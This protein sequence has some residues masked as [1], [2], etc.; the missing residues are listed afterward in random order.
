[1]KYT[2]VKNGATVTV[3]APYD[4]N[5]HC[6]FCVNKMDYQINPV[7]DLENVL[8]SMWRMDGITPLCDFVFT[9]GEPLA[10]LAMLDRMFKAVR[11]MN[12]KGSHHR[13]FV[14]TTFPVK[15]HD[16]V[17]YLNGNR[18]IIT[19]FNVSRHIYP[20]VEEC[21]DNYF[22]YVQIPIRINCVLT[23]AKEAEKGPDLIERF[24]RFR[25]IYGFQFR[26]NYTGVNETNLFDQDT[27]ERLKALL[28][29]FGVKEY[30]F[31]SD[32]FRWSAILQETPLISFHRTQCMSKGVDA[33]GN[34]FIGDIIVDPRGNIMDDWNEYGSPLDVEKYAEIFKKK[35]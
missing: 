13:L 22:S 24:K 29:A 14:N 20:F 10:D 12:A 34:V 32:R 8:R 11:E 7:F 25:S 26:D 23:T 15:S 21:W 9:G 6:P 33:K 31:T 19:G 18:D 2:T 35:K 5:N 16:D 30:G 28:K 17:I 1:M 3:F 4:C 27:N